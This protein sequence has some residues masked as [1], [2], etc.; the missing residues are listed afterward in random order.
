MAANSNHSCIVHAIQGRTPSKDYYY[1]YDENFKID[2]AVFN[3]IT[4]VYLYNLDGSFFKEFDGPKECAEYF[5]GNHTSTIYRSIRC[6]QL[7]KGY[8]I[9][10]EKVSCMKTVER[11]MTPKKVAQYDSNGTLVK[12]WDSIMEA[13]KNVSPNV[14]KCLKGQAKQTKGFTFKYY[15]E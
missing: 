3:K 2:K 13:R 15:E 1:S 6:G 8:Q 9:S 10:K 11:K 14:A 5:G 4:K 7:Y 12:V